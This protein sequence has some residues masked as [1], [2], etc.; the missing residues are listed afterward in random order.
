MCKIK[1]SLFK[2]HT[3]IL[4]MVVFILFIEMPEIRI[5]EK[6]EI[7]MQTIWQSGFAID[8]LIC[9][10]LNENAL[11]DTFSYNVFQ[12]RSHRGFWKGM[13]KGEPLNASRTLDYQ[14]MKTFKSNPI[15]S[16]RLVALKVDMSKIPVYK[17]KATILGMKTRK[18]TTITK[19]RCPI[20]VSMK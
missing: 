16:R 8:R 5:I 3:I 18:V 4:I 20:I 13:K 12:G 7:Q 14:Y 9:L 10:I 19:Y 11:A 1:E 6:C 2:Y 17:I 15:I